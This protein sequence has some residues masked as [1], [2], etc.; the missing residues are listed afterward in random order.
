MVVKVIELIGISDKSFEEA[1]N[2]AV[3]R[4][5]MTIKNITGLDIIGQ[6]VKVRDGKVAEYRVNVKAAFVVE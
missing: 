4:A 2:E 5:S 6:S 3:K 1:V